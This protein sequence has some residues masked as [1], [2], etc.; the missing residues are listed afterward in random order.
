MN[1]LSIEQQLFFIEFALDF[2]KNVKDPDDNNYGICHAFQD[3][4]NDE[5]NSEQQY[6]QTMP[7]QMA[8]MWKEIENKKLKRGSCWAWPMEDIN[9]RINYLTE[10][11]AKV[12]DKIITSG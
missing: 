7:L 5:F 11:R 3:W 1:K 10:Y 2:F 6:D 9:S 8:H 4:Y 12:V